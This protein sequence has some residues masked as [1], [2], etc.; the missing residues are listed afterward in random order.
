MNFRAVLPTPIDE[1]ENANRAACLWLIENAPIHHD[2]ATIKVFTDGNPGCD[3]YFRKHADLFTLTHGSLQKNDTTQWDYFISF[4]NAVPSSQLLNKKWENRKAIKKIYV[5]NKPI[6]IILRK[7]R[8]P[9]PID[10]T[11]TTPPEIIPI[12][13]PTHTTPPAPVS[14]P[15]NIFDEPEEISTDSEEENIISE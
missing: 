13:M 15:N 6:A 10:T 14:V 5:E 2:T 9:K 12:K 7:P 1:G 8:A 11:S 3:Y 4:A